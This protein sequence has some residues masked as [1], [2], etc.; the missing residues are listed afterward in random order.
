MTNRRP[1]LV[2][3]LP[4]SRTAW[5][6]HWLSH[7]GWNVS[8]EHLRYM[9]SL[10]DVRTWLT[11][12]GVGSVETSAAPFWRLLRSYSPDTKVLI[13]RRPVEEV[14]ESLVAVGLGANP[15]EIRKAICRLDRKLEQAEERLRQTMSVPYSA[16]ADPMVCAAAQ[17]WLTGDE[18]DVSWWM[19]WQA[20]NVQID[21]MALQRYVSAYLPQINKLEAM[22]RQAMWRELTLRPV[23]MAGVTIQEEPLATWLADCPHLFQQHCLEVG[24][25]P[26]NWKNK[27]IPLWHRLAAAGALQIMVAR[28]NGKPFGYLMTLL[29]PSLEA[30]GRTM[31]QNTAFFADKALPG[32]GLKLQRAAVAQLKAKGV[33]ETFMREGIRGDG[34]RM[35]ALYRRLGAESFGEMYRLGLED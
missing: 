28:C 11:L 25:S 30:E 6:A 18:F 7:A 13:V 4:R 20:T 33:Y 29:A 16:L 2:M 31:A 23:E 17:E 8:H 10:D 27:N 34:N 35:G 19:Q 26:D 5:L 24:E 3:A 32:L 9:R 15:A 14:V 21:F 12:E 1:F 22:A